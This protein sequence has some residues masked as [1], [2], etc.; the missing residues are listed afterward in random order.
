MLSINI[1]TPSSIM[2]HIK[3]NFKNKRLSFNFAQEGLAHRSGV[4]L[5][6]IKRFESTG[7]IS[8]KSLL[9]LALTLECLDDFLNIAITKEELISSIDE[10]IKKDS[11]PK[12]P[13]RGKL[14]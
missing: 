9:K 3:E 4:S 11:Q 2:L 6:S 5:G 7:E 13:K 1:N 12:T 8:L 14:K 10:L